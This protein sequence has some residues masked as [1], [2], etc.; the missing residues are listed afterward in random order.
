MSFLT[1][2]FISMAGTCFLIKAIAIREPIFM[3]S[4][5]MGLVMLIGVMWLIVKY[6]GE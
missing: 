5:A 6:K 1:Y 4:H 2:L 3:V